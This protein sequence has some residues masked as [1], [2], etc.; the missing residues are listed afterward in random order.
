MFKV[1]NGDFFPYA[2]KSHSYWTGFF[3]SRPALKYNIRKSGSIL[4]ATRQLAALAYLTDASTREAIE[5]LEMAMGVAQH[6]DAVTG[7]EKQHVANDYAKRLA[8]GVEKSMRVIEDAMNRLARRRAVLSHAWRHTPILYCP[9]LNN[10]ECAALTESLPSPRDNYDVLVYNQLARRVKSWITVPIASADYQVVDVEHN[11]A[12]VGDIAPVYAETNKIA[13]RRSRANYRLIFEAELPA[14]GFKVFNVRRNP[15]M[16]APVDP[17]PSLNNEFLLRNEHLELRFDAQ[18][19]LVELENLRAG[20][21]L[22]TALKQSY[23]Y[24]LSMAA[25][26][27]SPRDQSSGAYIFR[28]MPGSQIVCLKVKKYSITHLNRLTEV[29]QVYNEWI[30]QTIRVHDGAMHA[31]FE[32]QIG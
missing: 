3:T 10:S 19:N 21:G 24:Y 25:S 13:E 30:S 14:W 27:A 6:H 22:R 7:T 9:L 26:N 18:G 5:S 15:A 32:W 8:V 1:N 12:L 16:P 28:P 29:H 2:D 23:C 17:L 20:G 31:E 4:T 11:Y